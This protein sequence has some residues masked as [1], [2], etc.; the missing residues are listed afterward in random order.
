MRLPAKDAPEHDFMICFTNDTIKRIGEAL[1]RNDEPEKAKPFLGTDWESFK[2]NPAYPVLIEYKDNDFKPD[3][4]D[5]LPMERGI[6]H[7]IDIN[8]QNVAIYRQQ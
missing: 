2:I 5:G 6:E 7:R 1:K 3:L 8:D 4:P